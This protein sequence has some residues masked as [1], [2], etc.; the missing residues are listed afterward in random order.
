MAPTGEKGAMFWGA[1][2]NL[3]QTVGLKEHWDYFRPEGHEMGA[4]LDAYYPRPDL[5]TLKNQQAQTRYLQ[6][7]AYIR[8]KNIQIGYTL[9]RGWIQ[10]WD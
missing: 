5:S 4:N 1:V 9:P 8:L 2:N 6:N 10:K 7:A 3:Y